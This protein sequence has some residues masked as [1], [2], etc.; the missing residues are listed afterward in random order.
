MMK[1]SDEKVL[2]G[3]NLASQS[4]IG[5]LCLNR[6]LYSNWRAGRAQATVWMH[7][8]FEWPSRGNLTRNWHEAGK[9]QFV[10][11]SG[12]WKS[13]NYKFTNYCW[14]SH[15]LGHWGG[16]PPHPT[17][18]PA[19]FPLLSLPPYLFLLPPLPPPLLLLPPPS[20]SWE[21]VSSCK[22][23]AV[24]AVAEKV[25]RQMRQ[26]EVGLGKWAWKFIQSQKV[27]WFGKFQVLWFGQT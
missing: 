21:S 1:G 9:W 12:L 22:V 18:C 23:A 5:V 7:P 10:L 8:T 19:S 2:S 27:H 20:P 17:A 4:L 16:L 24:E 15:K 3:E 13:R 26:W 6:R 14:T 25:G 11:V